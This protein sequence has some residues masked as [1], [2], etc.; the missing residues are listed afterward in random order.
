[1]L[2]DHD[3]NSGSP[4][5]RTSKTT[6]PSSTSRSR[7]RSMADGEGTV[8]S[9]CHESDLPDLSPVRF[10]SPESNPEHLKTRINPCPKRESKSPKPKSAS[11]E[12]QSP[13][14]RSKTSQIAEKAQ[15]SADQGSDSRACRPKVPYRAAQ[16]SGAMPSNRAKNRHPD[17]SP[18][19]SPKLSSRG[20]WLRGAIYQFRVRVP[21][22]LRSA[23]K[24]D[25]VF[26]LFRS[27]I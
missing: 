4:Q 10:P 26:C 16:K 27:S 2:D 21:V 9:D 12:P 13:F 17:C 11:G 18:R 20:L 25:H 5:G 22:D 24:G 8:G 1:M 3:L 19:S 15:K 23:I 7:R 6:S 14:T